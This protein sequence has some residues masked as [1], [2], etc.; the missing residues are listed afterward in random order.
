MMA[1]IGVNVDHKADKSR[2]S[3]LSLMRPHPKDAI[4]IF[5]N[6]K[7]ASKIITNQWCASL[8]ARTLSII[9]VILDNALTFG[10]AIACRF[11]DQR[12][13]DQLGILL[14]GAYSLT[15]D[16]AITEKKATE[17]IETQDWEGE[18]F[19]NDESDERMCLNHILEHVISYNIDNQRVEKSTAN[20]V[21]EKPIGAHGEQAIERIGIRVMNDN[22]VISDSHSAL[23]SILKN[24]PY[25]KNWAKFLRR[26]PESEQKAG[27]KFNGIINRATAIPYDVVFLTGEK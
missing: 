24:T 13:G 17:W 16:S 26:L 21:H 7:E 1:S 18:G 19:T 20:I 4:D 22:I 27:V 25:E 5:D 14:A 11:N 12:I 3:I 8:R 15:S 6:I 2:I 23:K 10:R 9:P